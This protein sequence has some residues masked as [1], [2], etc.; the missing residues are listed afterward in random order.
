MLLS[1]QNANVV[2]QF[3]KLIVFSSIIKLCYLG[4]KLGVKIQFSHFFS[5]ALIHV[6]WFWTSLLFLF[7][8]A[9]FFLKNVLLTFWSREPRRWI[10]VVRK[11]NGLKI[12]INYLCLLLSFKN[13]IFWENRLSSFLLFNF[14]L[15]TQNVLIV[16]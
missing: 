10:L 13:F 14:F 1:V 5:R 16:I 11:L 6:Q 9:H 2:V 4:G 3:E 8:L 12:S 7:L 15:W